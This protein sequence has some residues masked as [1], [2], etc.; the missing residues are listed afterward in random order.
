[1]CAY[2]GI[3]PATTKDHIPPKGIFPLPRPD[4]L[5][6]V[7]SCVDCNHGA[8]ESDEA[9]R[10]YLSLH[11]GMDT[12]VTRQLWNHAALRGIRH[13]RRLLRRI[14]E[15]TTPTWLATP[16]GVIHSRAFRLLWD[17]EAHDKTIARMVRGF[18]F[19]H[20]GEVLGNRVH[21]E[22]Q[23]FRSLDSDILEATRECEH[24]SI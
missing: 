24:R 16:S 10:A 22:V 15:D 3:V 8:S 11:V 20:Y 23:W 13:N 4:D 9:F 14:K 5:I 2:C 12:P 1:M 18:Y 21:V 17:S 7:P 19:H 6:T